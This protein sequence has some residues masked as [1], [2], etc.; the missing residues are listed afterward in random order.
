M[1]NTNLSWITAERDLTDA[2]IPEFIME[3]LSKDS[4]VYKIVFLH[5]CVIVFDKIYMQHVIVH[6]EI[7][8]SPLLIFE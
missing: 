7:I 1:K 8:F 4:V 6:L 2:V 5:N 3:H